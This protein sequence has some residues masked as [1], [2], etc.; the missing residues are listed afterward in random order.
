MDD[1][2]SLPPLPRAKIR[3]ANVI[4]ELHLSYIMAAVLSS[5]YV[6]ASRRRL[7]QIP[8]RLLPS[9]FLEHRFEDVLKND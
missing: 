5:R 2:L 7:I 1:V 6:D 8:F 9:T 4:F 3:Y